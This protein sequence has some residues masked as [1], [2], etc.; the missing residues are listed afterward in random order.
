MQYAL[1]SPTFSKKI[2]VKSPAT[3]ILI[4][5]TRYL[6]KY[7]PSSVSSMTTTLPSAGQINSFS[8][9]LMLLFGT[10]K[11]WAKSRKKSKDKTN[12]VRWYH[13]KLFEFN[14][15]AVLIKTKNVSS[16]NRIL[17][18]SLC[19]VIKLILR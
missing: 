17:V 10:L 2:C 13:K 4:S 11:N 5:I 9:P 7:S 15:K 6:L 19:K 1:L 3:K 8:F 12:A 18:P 14:I 16:V